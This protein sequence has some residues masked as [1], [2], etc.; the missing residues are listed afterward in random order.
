MFLLA[1]VILTIVAVWRFLDLSAYYVRQ[2][3]LLH[4]RSACERGRWWLSDILV[5]VW[6][7]MTRRIWSIL[8]ASGMVGG[9][10]CNWKHSCAHC[11]IISPFS[12]LSLPGCLRVGRLSAQMQGIMGFVVP[13]AMSAAWGRRKRKV[14]HDC[15]GATHDSLG[16]CATNSSSPFPSAPKYTEL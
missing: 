14:T 3:V 10:A 16:K 8:L 2:M 13:M 5:T 6:G 12:F 7:D 9:W 4:L 15:F 1:L 11:H